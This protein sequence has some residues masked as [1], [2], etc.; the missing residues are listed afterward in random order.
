MKNQS[1]IGFIVLSIGLF[2][3]G[4]Y[5]AFEIPTPIINQVNITGN[6]QIA[7]ADLRANVLGLKN[8]YHRLLPAKLYT[9]L[10]IKRKRKDSLGIKPSFIQFLKSPNLTYNPVW[11]ATN[12]TQIQRYYRENGFLKAHIQSKIDTI[13]MGGLSGK[14]LTKR[15]TEV[16]SYLSEKSNKSFPI[17][18]VG[19]IHS[20]SDAIEKINAGASLVQLYTGFI[21]EGP[22]LVKA[23]NKKILESLP[24]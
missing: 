3:C 13:G 4:T 2:S 20:A 11:L 23:I 16:I 19:G 18:G 22:V 10:G 7:K 12:T 9:Y 6:Q 15:S 17:I 24:R 5:H 14:P 8:S 1:I 21:Y